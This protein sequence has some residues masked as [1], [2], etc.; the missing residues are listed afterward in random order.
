MKI[1]VIGAGI[2][3]L[4]AYIFLDKHLVQA[5][6]GKYSITIY[7]AYDV[8]Q[9]KY[10][11]PGAIA[12]TNNPSHFTPKM[13]GNA[14]GIGKNGLS[15]LERMDNSGNVLKTVQATGNVVGK[16]KM[17]TA[18]GWKIIDASVQAD[19][20]DGAGTVMIARQV[21]WEIL[22]DKVL[23]IDKSAIIKKN[24]TKIDAFIEGRVII[25]FSD[26][27]NDTADL[28]IG[29]DGLRSTV[30]K[31][32][33]S[34][35]N[36]MHPQSWLDWVLRRQARKKDY[37]TPHY[38]GLTGLGGF[39]PGTVLEQIGFQR[40][41]MSITFGP[42]G[43]FGHGYIG[44]VSHLTPPSSIAQ[45]EDSEPLAAWWSTFSSKVPRPY[46]RA[47]ESEAAT[48]TTSF[49]RDHALKDLLERH[50][51]WADES[52]RAI[53][54]YVKNN[55]SI[56]HIYPTY[57]TPELPTWTS[58][59]NV[60][61]IGDAAH[62]LQPSSGQG[63]CQA[64]EDA[65]A[66]ALFLK[67]FLNQEQDQRKAIA[68]ALTET[69]RLRKPRVRKVYDASQKMSSN[70]MNMGLIQEYLM[71]FFIWMASKMG[72]MDKY[73]EDLFGYDLPREVESALVSMKGER[74]ARRTQER[75]VGDQ[76][77]EELSVEVVRNIVKQVRRG[78]SAG[79]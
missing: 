67:H 29:A 58:K 78:V 10:D 22:R 51:F 1:I 54:T 33:F 61:L 62:A 50:S 70:K 53:L 48:V 28:L 7:E 63:A 69:V 76:S 30:R 4:S 66:V 24:I 31:A 59:G 71:Y 17:G 27:P 65:E 74:S 16:W 35:H 5:H 45:R 21:F 46:Q 20:K 49:D 26:G 39:V 9:L 75:A 34:E 37:I 3:G 40:D 11:A 13:I 2:A 79:K 36:D 12:T 56:E 32:I 44:N 72:F 25:Q 47:T 23:E 68:F 8:Q 38:E 14:I 18:R 60:I 43:F 64:L 19:G 73:N 42:N 55:V 15:V 77:D 41:A 6:P 52:I 57:T